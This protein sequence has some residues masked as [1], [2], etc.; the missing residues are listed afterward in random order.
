MVE[1][2]EKNIN[3]FL[4]KWLGLPCSMSSIDL[5]GRSTKLHFY[6]SSL[7]EESKVIRSREVMMYRDSTDLKVASAGIY[8][9]TGRNWQAHKGIS[10]AEAHNSEKRQ[11]VQDE[12]RTE[13]EV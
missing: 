2:W 6:L 7:S 3:Q 13:V 10:R 5:F 12:I 9:K 8:V 1:V 11:L 4:R